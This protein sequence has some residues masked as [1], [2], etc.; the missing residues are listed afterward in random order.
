MACTLLHMR[1]SSCDQGLQLMSFCVGRVVNLL[2]A[3]TFTVSAPAVASLSHDQGACCCLL[4]H[5][6]Q[7]CC[8]CDMQ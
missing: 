6:V 3:Q 1:V 4:S 2:A 8:A 7:L 5:D